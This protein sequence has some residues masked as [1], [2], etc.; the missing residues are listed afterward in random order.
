MAP[1]RLGRKGNGACRANLPLVAPSAVRAA[2][3]GRDMRIA[4][5]SV[6]KTALGL[7]LVVAL[8]PLL[9]GLN[10]DAK[11]SDRASGG[12][13]VAHRNGKATRLAKLPTA[14]TY[15]IGMHALEPTLG[16]DPSGSVYFAAAG[17]DGP[18]GLSAT[19]IL[20]SDDEA[21]SWETVSPRVLDRNSMPLSLD[22]YVWVDDQ[23]DGDNARIF[24]IDLT[25]ACSYM[26]FSDDQGA[27]WITNPLS[28][29]RPVNDHQTLFS[30]PP[31]STP[32][33]GYPNIVYYC[34]N[35]VGSSACSRSLD[36]GITFSPT[37]APAYAGYEPNN[38]DPGFYGQNGF[39]GG[40]HGHGHVGPDGTVF[41]PREF[42]GKPMLAI[43]PDEGLTWK[44]VEVSK[45]R[46]ISQP[47]EGAGHPSVTTDEAGNIYYM[48]IGDDDRLPYLSVSKDGGDT[49]SK[50]VVAGPPG[51]REANLPQIDARGKGK[52]ALVYYGSTN[53]PFP[54]CKAE[55]DAKAYAPTTWNGY[56]TVSDDALSKN[57]TFMTGIVNDPL[58]PLIRARCG[59]GRCHMAYDFIDVEIGPDGQAFGAFVDGCMDLCSEIQ[60]REGDYEGL[61]TTLVGA[62]RLI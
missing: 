32:T 12:K 46:S 27:S 13:A 17:F 16:I 61:V 51:L 29:G 54:D 22:P 14:K 52:I 9:V 43:S 21:K 10:A 11:G 60:P 37:G 41:L 7:V 4:G 5:R 25:L 48:W 44:V 57:P 18:A 40:L 8:V 24:T 53:S 45:V 34:W 58:D 56:I 23:I 36:G 42:C 6:D 28:C 33:V 19:Q 49:W 39:C 26:S 1:D 15:S 30:G 20:R 47:D 50:P 2:G 3:G 35:D 31:V 62:P 59:P 55:C 38:G